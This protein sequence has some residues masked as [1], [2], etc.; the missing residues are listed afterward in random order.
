MSPGSQSGRGAMTLTPAPN[1]PI[2]FNIVNRTSASWQSKKCFFFLEGIRTQC[3]GS[4][5]LAFDPSAKRPWNVCLSAEFLVSSTNGSVFV[6]L[7]KKHAVLNVEF[8]FNPTLHCL[9]SLLARGMLAA[10][11]T[12]AQGISSQG[13]LAK[14]RHA[15]LQEQQQQLEQ[16]AAEVQELQQR[17]REWCQW[18]R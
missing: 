9:L 18:D 17:K 15:K 5:E 7:E 2:F 3:R 12:A 4:E 8:P 1:E 14:K 11:S 6:L 10:Q 16:G 13:A